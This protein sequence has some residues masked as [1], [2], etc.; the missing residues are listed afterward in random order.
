MLDRANYC[1]EDGTCRSSYGSVKFRVIA[2]AQ[3][4]TGISSGSNFPFKLSGC[5]VVDTEDWEC[6]QGYFIDEPIGKSGNQW[7][8]SEDYEV[9]RVRA[10]WWLSSLGG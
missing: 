5:I 6:A 8:V 7:T 4:V 9:F 1:E 2:E 3:T 10:F